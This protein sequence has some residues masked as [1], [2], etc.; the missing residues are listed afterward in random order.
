M[1]VLALIVTF[2]TTGKIHT[3]YQNLKEKSGLE[4]SYSISISNESTDQR[5]DEFLNNIPGNHYTQSNLWV[6]VNEILGWKPLRLILSKE[7]KIV[8]GVQIFIKEPASVTNIGYIIKGPIFSLDDHALREYLFSELSNL[9][10]QKKITFIALQ[11]PDYA[12][13]VN[14]LSDFGFQPSNIKMEPTATILIDLYMDQESLLSQMKIQTRY[15]IR[16]SQKKGIVVREG[17][18]NDFNAF[19]KILKHTA[20]RKQFEIYPIQYFIK[21][22]EV[23]CPDNHIKIFL[24]E[25][26]GKLISAQLLLIFG[27]TVINKMGV[28]SGKHSNL[29][30]NEALLWY[31]ILWSKK[32]GYHYFNLEGI[33]KK[34][35]QAVLINEPIPD[36]LK[37]SFT[38]FKLGFGG[39][40]KQLSDVYEYIYN[41]GI[42]KFYSHIID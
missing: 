35:A 13:W 40:V 39:Q 25:F 1:A 19:Y 21:M 15:N 20:R 24:S 33:D 3:S 14:E 36:R 12:V 41:N 38:T 7:Q 22:W 6:R 5:W 11:P 2:L 8:A 23:L 37:Y 27:D 28:W 18:L 31:S 29:K 42:R 10:R 32:N 9:A 34:A 17:S 4:K 26:R 16:L 30:P